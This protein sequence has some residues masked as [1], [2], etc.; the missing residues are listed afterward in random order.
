AITQ[1]KADLIHIIRS[2]L[3]DHFK[4]LGKQ[5]IS[6]PCLESLFFSVFE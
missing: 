5:T 1:F 4:Q 6:F 3:K 2:K